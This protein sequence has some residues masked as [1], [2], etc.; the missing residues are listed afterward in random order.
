M[1]SFI[2][3]IG[4]INYKDRYFVGVPG[5]VV[6]V[7]MV[8]WMIGPLYNVPAVLLTSIVGPEGSCAPM[9]KWPSKGTGTSVHRGTKDILSFFQKT[10]TL[11]SRAV[12]TLFHLFTIAIYGRNCFNMQH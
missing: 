7:M 5:H 10:R 9:A 8:C 12:V 3:S 6:A 1:R 2:S 11:P 4:V